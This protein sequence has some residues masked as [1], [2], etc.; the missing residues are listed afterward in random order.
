MPSLK[1][2]PQM[3]DGI[4][5]VGW[6]SAEVSNSKQVIGKGYFLCKKQVSDSI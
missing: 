3:H 1:K 6:Y 4:R 5:Y 2:M